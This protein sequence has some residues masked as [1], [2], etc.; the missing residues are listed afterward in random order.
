MKL[1]SLTLLEYVSILS[2]SGPTDF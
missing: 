2:Y 1:Y